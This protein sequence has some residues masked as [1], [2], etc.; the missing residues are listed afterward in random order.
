MNN[1]K[2][3]VA[4]LGGGMSA[5]TAAYQL[6]QQNEFDIT[7]YQM[8]WRLG[9]KGAS[10]RNAGMN[11]RIEEHGLHVWFGFY[12][13]AFRLMRQV[14]EECGRPA[15]SPLA[16]VDDAFKPVNDLNMV[17]LW[18]GKRMNWN[19][20]FPH[21]DL[22]PGVGGEIATA[23]SSVDLIINW[24]IEFA[25]GKIDE[26]DTGSDELKDGEH[27]LIDFP[28]WIKEVGEIAED[29]VK[30]IVLTEIWFL[31]QALKLWSKLEANKPPSKHHHAI[32]TWLM[33]K[34]LTMK[35]NRIKDQVETDTEVRRH[36]TLLYLACT[37]FTGLI[38]DEVL[39]HGFSPLDKL[40][41][42]DWFYQHKL[43][44]S[45][46]AN[47]IAYRSAPTQTV[48][49]LFFHYENGDTDKPR[50]SAGIALRSLLRI[51][52]GYKGSVLWFMQ[53]GMGDTV[54]GPLYE[55]LRRRGVKFKF[56]NRVTNIGL[57]ENTDVKAVDSI[58]ISRQVNLKVGEYEPLVTVKGLPCWPSNPA[59]DQIVEGEELKARGINL[60]R[61][62]EYSDWKDTGGTI[63]LKAGEDFD[64][65]ILGITLAAL[66][67]ITKE[68]MAASNAWKLMCD[69]IKTVQTQAIQVW[70]NKDSDELGSDASRPVIGAYVEPYASLTD[71]THLI[72][73]ENWRDDQNVKY[74]SYS[75][76]VMKE[77]PDE[78]QL[79]ANAR[80]RFNGLDLLNN[81]A[82]SL[83][84]KAV[85]PKN[86]E[87]LDWSTVIAPDH[88][89]GEQRFDSQYIRANIDT[90]EQY[91]QSLPDTNQYRIKAGESGFDRLI[92]TGTW[93]D[94][95]FNI[96]CIE[97][98]AISGIQA[99]RVLTGDPVHIVGE[100]EI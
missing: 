63:T 45:D 79:N 32:I 93:I 24:I 92:L 68:L 76:G 96:S 72:K 75:C 46:L 15:G 30:A 39:V 49:D 37:T 8:G 70:F 61:S 60:E 3:K 82:A 100:K 48:Y 66:L 65:V 47:D 80:A 27:H 17:E 88:I 53:A 26:H 89:V 59:Y 12:E 35:W 58:T 19:V 74:L 86:P 69:Q 87:G 9:G 50:I 71:F 90:N 16:T 4:I 41:M 94:C 44:D 95:G 11:D 56:F 38:R 43:V 78:T 21:D 51:L 81:H 22:K 34:A 28:D 1:E 91:V 31:R 62:P 25:E 14:Y 73:M 2:K 7:V 18:D 13:N 83:W 77:E 57:S 20:E 42:V 67:P 52:A 55:V 40:D 33:E 99:A 10:G 29:A 23:W 54:F 6:A 84:P 36:W 5:L 98:A 64:F 85:D 97:A